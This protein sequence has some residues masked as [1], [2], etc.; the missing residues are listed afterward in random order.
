MLRKKN[1]RSQHAFADVYFSRVS[2]SMLYVPCRQNR[3]TRLCNHARICHLRLNCS[4]SQLSVKLPTQSKWKRLDIQNAS[5][6]SDISIGGSRERVLCMFHADQNMS[7]ISGGKLMSPYGGSWIC[8]GVCSGGCGLHVMAHSECG[9]LLCAF[10]IWSFC[11]RCA[12][13]KLGLFCNSSAENCM[14][15][16]EFGPGGHQGK[17]PP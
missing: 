2:N 5:Q 13:P 11:W 16:K 10:W 12:I 3:M 17:P 7:P 8:Q 14:K 6:V 15:M 9:L 1:V 4:Q